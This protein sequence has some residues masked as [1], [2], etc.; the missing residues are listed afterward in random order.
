MNKTHLHSHYYDARE[1]VDWV[2]NVPF[3]LIHAGCLAVVWTGWSATAVVVAFATLA[4]RMFGL[5]G[6]FH[7]YFSHRSYKTSRLFQ[8]VLAWLGCAAAQKGPLWWAAHHRYH[9]RHS[10]THEDVHPPGVKGF[11]WAHMGWVMSP[12]NDNTRYELMPDFADYPEMRWVNE[13]HYM[14]PASLIVV[15]L[16]LGQGLKVWA[17]EL[18]AG[19]L[20]LLVWGFF[21]STTVLYHVTFSVNS[22][23]HTF[24]RRRY[25]T[26]DDSR[27]N[28]WVALLTAGEGWH[29][30]HHRFPGS[31][32]QGFYWWEIDMTHYAL[33]ILSWLG[34]VWDLREP[35]RAVLEEGRKGD[36][37]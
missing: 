4:A 33:R 8:F 7:R 9:H 19:P 35:S 3:L 16:G 32:R 36:V 26:D 34:I 6:G 11:F 2:A 37:V 23:G 14:P 28:L 24:G 22:F 18:G 1:Y 21:I 15:L 27:N 29:N 17:P 10:D 13:H 12:S 5:T 20:Q 31:A 30:N 25:G